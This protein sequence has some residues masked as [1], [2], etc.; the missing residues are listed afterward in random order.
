MANPFETESG[1]F[2]VVRNDEGQLS[3]WPEFAVV[4][5]GWHV[6]VGPDT[7]RACLARIERSG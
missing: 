2:L 6:V 1:G 3:L 7:R 4:P 5:A